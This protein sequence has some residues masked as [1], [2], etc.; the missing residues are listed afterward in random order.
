[1]ETSF[2]FLIIMCH[3]SQLFIG[4]KGLKTPYMI[5]FWSVRRVNESNIHLWNWSRSKKLN[6]IEKNKQRAKNM[7]EIKWNAATYRRIVILLAKR[8]PCQ[9]LGCFLKQDVMLEAGI[10]RLSTLLPSL[11][12]IRPHWII[13]EHNHSCRTVTRTHC[14]AQ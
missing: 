14:T 1:M 7:S 3:C 9:C 5:I 6:S 12:T 8:H 10:V 11:S 13:T 2:T 4:L